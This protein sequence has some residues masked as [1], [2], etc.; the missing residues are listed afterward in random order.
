GVDEFITKLVIN[1]L[2]GKQIFEEINL[3]AGQDIMLPKLNEGL[4]LIRIQVGNKI[5]T[6]KQLFTG[7]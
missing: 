3:A 5:I 6:K 7:M 1:D 4:Y 2:T